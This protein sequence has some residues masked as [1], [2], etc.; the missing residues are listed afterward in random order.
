MISAEE[1]RIVAYHE[2]GHASLRRLLPNTDPVYKISIIPRQAAGYVLIPGGRSRPGN[3][4]MVRGI[5]LRLH[6]AV[7]LPKN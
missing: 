4:T 3:A 5:S 7:G 2:A 6:W 1:K